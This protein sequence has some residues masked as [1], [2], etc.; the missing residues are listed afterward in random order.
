[1]INNDFTV[2]SCTKDDLVSSH[3]IVLLETIC[4]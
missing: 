3:D 4:T 2:Y 1:M